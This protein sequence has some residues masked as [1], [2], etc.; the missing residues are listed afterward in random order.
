ME[1]RDF[2]K[3]LGVSALAGITPNLAFAAAPQGQYRNLLVLIEL[4]GG[5]D[6]LNTV[7]PYANAEYYKLRPKLAIPR[8]Q[9]LQ[10]DERCGLHPAMKALMPL[11]QASEMAIVQGV[12]YPD[13][14]L[15]HFRSIEIWD[16]ASNSR[17]YLQQGWLSRTFAASP[18][19]RAYAADGI[20]LGS[21][22]MGPLGGGDTRAIVLSNP[23]QFLRQARQ[24]NMP[25]GRAENAALS[26]LLK[27]ESDIRQAASHLRLDA[28]LRAEFPKSGF[29]NSLKTACQVLAG[30]SGIAVARITHGGFDTHSNQPGTQ[31]RLLTELADGLAAFKAA[32][33]ELGRWNS[34]LIMT[35]AEFGRRPQENQS[36]GTD[37]GTASAHFMLGGRV[38]G[39]LYGKPPQLDRLDNGNLVY[40]V[41][42]REIYATALESWWGLP[43]RGVLNGRFKPLD[44]VKA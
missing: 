43:S 19:P 5:N 12:G 3:M 37:H 18:P 27:V 35:Y 42:F 1:R 22:E 44:V 30:N 8:E 14:N 23:Q 6:G 2:L 16:T 28:P 38:K 32:L 41:D 31:A 33:V 34:T 29:G 7:A 25:E 17:E 36:N 4:K 20:V 15:S 39:G 9:V 26:H 21:E 13:P 24:E 11:W 10:L 40:G